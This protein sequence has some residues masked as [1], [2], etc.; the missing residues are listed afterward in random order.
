MNYPYILVCLLVGVSYCVIGHGQGM[1]DL[2]QP[3]R[4]N[5]YSEGA[6]L[7]SGF[8]VGLMIH[9]CMTP[10]AWLWRLV[11]VVGI[12]VRPVLAGWQS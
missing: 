6:G 1:S 4:M 10:L 5:P 9:L 2:A 3:E 11:K 8:W 7:S 12:V